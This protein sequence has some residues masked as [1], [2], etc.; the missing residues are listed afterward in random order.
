MINNT[1]KFKY[2]FS[3]VLS[4]LVVGYVV[5][6]W[7]EPTAP[8]PSGYTAPLN[9]SATAQN[10]VGELGAASFVDA[11]DSDYYINPSGDSVI[12]GKIAAAGEIDDSDFGSTLINKAYLETKLNKIYEM[13][14]N[15]AG[16]TFTRTGTNPP[17]PPGSTAVQKHWLAKTCS[18]NY[19][20]QCENFY[21][22]TYTCTTA[23]TWAYDA[24]LCIYYNWVNGL[25]CQSGQVCTA[26]SWDKILCA[27][28]N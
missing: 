3:I 12:A 4:C 26:S 10:K 13:I 21:Y 8:M 27:S 2:L 16:E 28:D 6:S 18:G 23:S 5:F 11:D 9:T 19:L 17:C 20:G 14:S 1:M 15:T 25:G 7:S 22:G 24:P